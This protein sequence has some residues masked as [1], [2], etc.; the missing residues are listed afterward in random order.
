MRIDTRRFPDHGAPE[1]NE[2]KQEGTDEAERRRWQKKLNGG[3]LKI[4]ITTDT[5]FWV[6]YGS[7]K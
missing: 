4:S 6:T 1:T 7:Y 2:P 5:M 3:T